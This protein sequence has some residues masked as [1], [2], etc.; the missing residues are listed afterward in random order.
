MYFIMVGKLLYGEVITECKYTEQ[1]LQENIKKLF[2]WC[3]TLSH[4][5]HFL[6]PLNIQLSNNGK[7]ARKMILKMKFRFHK[8]LKDYNLRNILM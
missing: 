7:N 2:W 3:F 4:F 6:S 8:N 5:P 1:L